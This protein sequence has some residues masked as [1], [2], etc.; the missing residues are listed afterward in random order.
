[1]LECKHSAKSKAFNCTLKTMFVWLYKA[2]TYFIPFVR[3][4][5]LSTVEVAKT[6]NCSNGDMPMLTYQFNMRSHGSDML[7]GC[8]IRSAQMAMAAIAAK[9]GIKVYDL[10]KLFHDRDGVFSFEKFRE[11]RGEDDEVHWWCATDASIALT[12]L[13]AS[14]GFK[15]TIFTVHLESDENGLTQ[16]GIDEL[17]AHASNP[18]FVGGVGGVGRKGFMFTSFGE[19]KSEFLDPH[20]MITDAALPF[21]TVRDYKRSFF[22]DEDEMFTVDTKQ[23]SPTVCLCFA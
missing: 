7:W 18:S 21:L 15:A 23:V 19:N 14:A 22:L 13:C 20:A 2:W 6:P 12:N 8:V 16:A 10:S 9:N 3:R 5:G 4:S 1:M 17:V 11:A